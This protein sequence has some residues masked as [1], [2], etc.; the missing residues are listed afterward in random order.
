MTDIRIACETKDAL[1]YDQLI[2]FQ[3]ELKSL[4]KANYEKLKKEIIETGFAFPI[5]VWKDPKDGCNY[6]LGGHQRQ[7]AIKQMV[8]KE[9]FNSP[10][11]PIIYVHAED[12]KAARRRILQ[13]VSQYGY[14]EHDGLYEFMV[15]SELDIEDVKASF[16]IPSMSLETFED[17]YFKD[18][19]PAEKEE[20]QLQEKGGVTCPSC[21]HKFSIL[22]KVSK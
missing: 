21:G 17:N 11:L 13:D 6:L 10:P 22:E 20:E 2:P 12:K 8:E 7:R 16:D 19:V 4:S 14:V 15:D 18:Q 1:P 5:L 3:G 9:G